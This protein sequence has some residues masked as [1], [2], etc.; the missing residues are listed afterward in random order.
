MT[1][2]TLT[3]TGYVVFIVQIFLS[4]IIF[5]DYVLLQFTIG[6]FNGF[7][8][9]L[10]LFALYL[11]VFDNWLFLSV[12]INVHVIFSLQSFLF[13]LFFLSSV[14]VLHVCF[15][16]CLTVFLSVFFPSCSISTSICYSS[17]VPFLSRP[18][19]G[20]LG[21]AWSRSIHLRSPLLSK[22]ANIDNTKQHRGDEWSSD[23]G[24]TVLRLWAFPQGHAGSSSTLVYVWLGI[25]YRYFTQPVC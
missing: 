1:I 10:L 6:A 21:Q 16:Q 4:L 17:F 2:S 23:L 25:F 7:F 14:V 13:S 12:L 8:F 15:L 18:L 5:T 11:S 22:W 9:K 20:Y 3:Y 24:S 19:F